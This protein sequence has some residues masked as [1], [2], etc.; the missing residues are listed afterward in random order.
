MNE[1]PEELKEHCDT[2]PVAAECKR[3]FGDYWQDKSRG[4]VGCVYPF[5]AP[6]AKP[7]DDAEVQYQDYVASKPV[8]QPELPKHEPWEIA[9]V[10][11]GTSAGVLCTSKRNGMGRAR[12][13]KLL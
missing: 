7:A 1:N 6:G 13:G 3:A 9:H 5:P 2:C 10:T 12:Q 4:G 11:R 8:A